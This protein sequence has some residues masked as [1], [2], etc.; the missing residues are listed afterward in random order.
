MEEN[1]IELLEQMGIGV[2]E[3]QKVQKYVITYNL[4]NVV[5]AQ[6][7]RIMQLFKYCGCD[8]Q[9][10]GKIIVD[11][12]TILQMSHWDI[13]KAAYV[14]DETKA[15]PNMEQSRYTLRLAQ[16]N[17]VYLR[18]EYLKNHLNLVPS[19]DSLITGEDKFTTNC[20]SILN[21]KRFFPY[22]ENLLMQFIK[23]PDSIEGKEEK[24]SH[25][26][27][28][29]AINWHRLKFLNERNKENDFRKK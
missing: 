24:L 25:I 2:E 3:I 17:R 14:W 28:L 5:Y 8:D 10:I 9:K 22:Y 20:R 11:N 7:K 26:I 23:E 18:N 6:I 1:Y 13:M 29:K 21:G 27:T 4:E 15:L 19:Y 12:L 16:I